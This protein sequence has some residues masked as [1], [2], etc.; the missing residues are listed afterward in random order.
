MN[1]KTKAQVWVE[2]AVYSL[3]GLTIIAILLTTAMPQINK[4]KDKATISKA[5]TSLNNL[6]NEIN[7]IQQ[8]PGSVRLIYF[9]LSRG[10]LTFDYE[11]NKIIY[12]LENTNLEL[13]ELG[14][15]I[16][17][18]EISLRTEE[19]GKKFN[20]FLT[21]DYSDSLN[22]THGDEKNKILQ[23]GTTDYRIKAENQGEGSVDEKIQIDLSIL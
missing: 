20:I 18:G 17:E 11:N 2:T 10:T 22:L 13:S 21:L 7:E 15:E 6:N 3:I 5:T 14:R 12:L 23:P 4:M 16:P 8:A 19:Y 1:K 9:K